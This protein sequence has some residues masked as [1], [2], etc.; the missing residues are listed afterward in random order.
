MDPYSS[1]YRIPNNG[2]H[3]PFPHSLLRTR[4]K[5]QSGILERHSSGS[6]RKSG[7]PSFGVL[8]I[9]ILLFRVLY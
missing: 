5:F 7:V 4:Q 9:R 1:P 6:F 3:N 8:I 2:A